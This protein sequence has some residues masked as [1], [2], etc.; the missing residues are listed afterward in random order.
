MK[1]YNSIQIQILYNPFFLLIIE[2]RKVLIIDAWERI[3]QE[4]RTVRW[5]LDLNVFLMA[6]FHAVGRTKFM[7]KLLLK[8]KIFF[9]FAAKSF[10]NSFVLTLIFASAIHPA[11]LA[12]MQV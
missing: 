10:F 3:N 4:K 2:R 9:C 1:T 6:N 8:K 11:R 7:R 12:S 5:L